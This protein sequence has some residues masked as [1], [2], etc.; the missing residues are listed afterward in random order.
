MP[1]GYEYYNMKN[2]ENEIIFR[3]KDLKDE[4]QALVSIY[5]TFCKNKFV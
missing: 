3:I 5:F 1:I 4:E 2:E